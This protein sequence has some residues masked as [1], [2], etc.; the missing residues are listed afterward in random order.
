MKNKRG[1]TLVTVIIMVVIMAIIAT[2]SITGG[3]SVIRNAQ[4]QAREKNLAD[5][6]VI[7]GREAAKVGTGGVLTPANIKYYGTSNFELPGIEIN[8]DGTV[9][10]VVKEIGDDWYYLDKADL[11]EMGIEYVE[12]TYIVNYK[13]NVVLPLSTTKNIHL[14][15]EYYNSINE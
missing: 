9:E 8:D 3:V 13:Y 1:V 5:V 12:E 15:I 7:I 6:K 4:E 11:E 14:D 10:E 2:V